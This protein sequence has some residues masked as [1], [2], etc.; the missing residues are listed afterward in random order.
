MVK[1]KSSFPLVGTK[2]VIDANEFK[3]SNILEKL[4]TSRT[5]VLFLTLVNTK[6]VGYPIICIA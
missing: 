1:L 6:L 4:K 3:L 5:W 2:I